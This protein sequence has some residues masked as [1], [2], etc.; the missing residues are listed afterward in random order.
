MAVIA[1]KNVNK[2]TTINESLAS[3]KNQADV[4]N[5]IRQLTNAVRGIYGT[6]EWDGGVAG[7][8][9]YHRYAMYW[10]AKLT[11]TGSGSTILSFPFTVVDSLVRVT[12]IATL[13]TKV[14]YIEN[15]NQ[16]S[17]SNLG[18]KTIVEVS[19]VKNTKE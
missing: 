14:Y 6:G 4:E 1:K 5:S 13:T 16:L 12:D 17:V 7:S 2:A 19:F 11:F 18:G 9:Y 3:P 15:N 8:G 10:D